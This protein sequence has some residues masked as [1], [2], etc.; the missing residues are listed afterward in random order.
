MKFLNKLEKTK[1][2]NLSLIRYVHNF[3]IKNTEYAMENKEQGQENA[4]LQITK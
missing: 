2:D 3:I 1:M 4:T